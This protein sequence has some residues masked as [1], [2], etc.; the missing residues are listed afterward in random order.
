MS[1]EPVENRQLTAVNRPV[2]WEIKPI[3]SQDEQSDRQIQQF[4][5][6]GYCLIW[7]FELT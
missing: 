7:M 1:F 5:T 2:N 4:P 3:S 6:V